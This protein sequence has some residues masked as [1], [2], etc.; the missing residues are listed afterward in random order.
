[1]RDNDGQKEPLVSRTDM[2]AVEMAC[3]PKASNP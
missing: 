3:L 1:M 2:M